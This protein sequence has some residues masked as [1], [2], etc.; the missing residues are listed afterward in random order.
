M[1]KYA[2]IL[3]QSNNY[4]R[5][6]ESLREVE[7]L[8]TEAI[9]LIEKISSYY[10]EKNEYDKAKKALE[11]YNEDMGVKWWELGY[12]LKEHLQDINLMEK[13]Y[14]KH[15]T[16]IEVKEKMIQQFT[17]SLSNT[18]FPNTIYKVSERLKKHMEF[19]RDAKI[20]NDA[21]HSEKLVKQ[22]GHILQ[23]RNTGNEKYFQ[24]EI[25]KDRRTLDS[26]ENTVVI[27]EILNNS[28][29]R[30]VASKFLNPDYRKIDSIRK[31]ILEQQDASLSELNNSYE[32]KVFFNE[33]QTPMEW[34]NNNIA[35]IKVSYSKEWKQIR[36]R[37][38]G[39]SEALLQGY[40]SEL[41]FNSLKYGDH[42]NGDWVNIEFHS[43]NT[44][45][46]LISE[47]TN[48]I[49]SEIKTLGSEAGLD[50]IGNDL[51]MLNDTESSNKHLIR[52]Q[53]NNHFI[54]KLFFKSDLLLLS[55]R[56]PDLSNLLE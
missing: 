41:F 48:R 51:Q 55:D 2:Q 13:E 30:L 16:K 7:D 21:Y 10:A 14:V 11:G 44:D 40:F 1:I 8:S 24:K 47:W 36:L 17:H 49:N 46:Y 53:K 3:Y 37:K 19:K 45:K 35:N 4:D 54:L 52:T 15:K 20:L 38:D 25:R 33:E 34:V 5:A 28:L 26:S 23:A 56:S 50:S 39:S 22:Q 29:A 32:E 6:L 9:E 18:L 42:T 12:P 31:Q 27:E 43:N